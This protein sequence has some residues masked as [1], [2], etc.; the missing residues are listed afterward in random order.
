[1]TALD[2]LRIARG[3]SVGRITLDRPAKLNALTPE[4]VREL[5]S[6]LEDWKR[7]PSIGAVL[8]DGAGS[9]G[10]CA[11]GDIAWVRK[12]ARARDRRVQ[13]FW[14]DEYRLNASI[15]SYP[16]PVVPFMHGIVMGGGVG[17][18][19]H[20]RHRIVTESTRLAMPEV[21]IGLIPDVGATWLFSR[22]PGEIGTYLALT[23]GRAGAA[24]AVA[25]GLAD[26]FV[27]EAALAA[28]KAALLDA[29]FHDDAGVRSLIRSFAA[30]PGEPVL[31][32]RRATIDRAFAYDSVEE[33]LGALKA[34]GSDF[35]LATADEMLTKSPTSLKLTLR[36]LRDARGLK[37]LESC[38]RLEY[39][40]VCRLLDSHDFHEG[41]RATVVDKDRNPTW[42]PA[43]L[44][45]VTRAALDEYF[46]S[47]GTGELLL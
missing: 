42:R 30:P 19:A 14:A 11:G 5:A 39:R 16:K 26:Y 17:I 36:A 27:P 41:I 20:A 25:L 18:S 23:G 28:L 31:L 40:L 3:G 10:F 35:A 29:D 15:A 38:L 45:S 1:M 37:S 34:D 44:G 46:T 13:A 9:R 24:D 12:H 43:G 32:H 6:L 8:I 21:A 22:A 33:T 4:M 47:L 7:D 2:S